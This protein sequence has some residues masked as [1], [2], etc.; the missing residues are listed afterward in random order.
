MFM[1][2]ASF[3]GIGISVSGRVEEKSSAEVSRVMRREKCMAIA[4]A[5]HHVILH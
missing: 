2:L 1:Q 5:K 3:L 4:M